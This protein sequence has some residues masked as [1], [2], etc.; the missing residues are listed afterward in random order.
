M[1][2]Y[3]TDIKNCMNFMQQNGVILYPTDTI[4]GLGCDVMDVEA[5]RKI[6]DIKKRDEHKSF[7]LLMT[8]VKQLNQFIASPL[9]NLDSIFVQ[10]EQP[11]TI[12]Y[13]DAIN[14]PNEVMG[15][16][17]TIAVRITKDP[18]CRSLIKRL[19]RPIVSTSA[20]LSGQQSPLFFERIDEEIKQNADYIVKWRQKD[21]TPS[22]ASTI[23]KLNKDGS[24]D[25]IR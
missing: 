23:Y 14:L 20:N 22:Q 25:K 8:D 11:T 13:P 17:Q 19:R 18:F 21:T 4:W 16:N 24:L 10:F 2:A 5:I 6:Y 3:E 1:S 9:P 15:P 12:I 7:V